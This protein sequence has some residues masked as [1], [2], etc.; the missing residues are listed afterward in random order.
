M[1]ISLEFAYLI[2]GLFFLFIWLLLFVLH[3]YSRK[4]M[5]LVSIIFGIVGIII[6]PFYLVDWWRPLTITNTPVGFED[7]L[8]AFTVGGI[9][10][11]V[12]EF[13]LQK[14]VRRPLSWRALLSLIT[15]MDFLL[16]VAIPAFL[17]IG[18][19]L[20]GFNSLEASVVA[21]AVPLLVMYVKRPGL[22][23]NSVVSGILILLVAFVVYSA[24]DFLIP[25]WVNDFWYFFNTPPIII[26]NF[27]IDDVIWYLM[28]GAYVG[29]LYEFMFHRRLRSIHKF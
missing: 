27:P 22:I 24:V 25:G 11:A 14:R 8:Y 9:A 17:F 20:L 10:S 19:L 21:L 15:L 26:F 5:I 23:V 13:V 3:P 7:F 29:I 6:E 28:F 12:Y 2:L 1:N 4:E 18:F 16:I